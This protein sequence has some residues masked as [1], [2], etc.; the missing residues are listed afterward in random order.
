MK[1]LA[2]VLLAAVLTT[3]SAS[4]DPTDKTSP[5]SAASVEPDGFLRPKSS[6]TPANNTTAAKVAGPKKPL[7]AMLGKDSTGKGSTTTFAS[8]DPSVYCVWKAETAMKGE[9]VRVAWYSEGGKDKKLTENT[10]AIP[11]AGSAGGSA[12]IE[13][14]AGGFP[15][16]KYRA[17]VYD[18]G[19]LAKSLKFTITK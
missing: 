8:S 14:P 11:G 12:H 2:S 9:K 15:V 3:A 18:D 13:K 17:D 10:Q 19:K 5:G 4:A 6:P 7:T 1:Y 16:G